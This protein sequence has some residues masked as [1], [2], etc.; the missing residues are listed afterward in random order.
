[1]L[2]MCSAVHLPKPTRF[3]AAPEVRDHFAVNT[4]VRAERFIKAL[5]W[6]IA[7]QVLSLLRNRKLSAKEL[8]LLK[9]EIE[10]MVHHYRSMPTRAA[11][12]VE[13]FGQELEASEWL[14]PSHNSQREILGTLTRCFRTACGIPSSVFRH[15]EPLGGDLFTC[16]HVAVTPTSEIPQ[17]P[18]PDQVSLCCATC[19]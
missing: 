18:Y 6:P 16:Y 2:D 1:M 15:L 10:I 13:K 7:F 19:H 12:I 4:L 17:G 11:Y 5:P 3:L 14:R 8:L 9:D